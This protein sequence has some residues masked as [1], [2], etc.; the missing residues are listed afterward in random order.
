[1]KR[2]DHVRMH[3]KERGSKLVE[4]KCPGCGKIFVREKRN[5]FLQ[6]MVNIRAV[7][8]NVQG[9]LAIYHH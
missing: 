7:V 4:L 6:K 9:L 2:S 3:V 5:T 8:E 1:M